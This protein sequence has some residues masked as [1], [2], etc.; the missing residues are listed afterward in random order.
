MR[1]NKAIDRNES[2]K[3][4]LKFRSR[5]YKET[6]KFE[7]RCISY[8][9][10]GIN[11]YIYLYSLDHL[12]GWKVACRCVVSRQQS[13]SAAGTRLANSL[14]WRGVAWRG[15]VW[16]DPFVPQIRSMYSAYIVQFHIYNTA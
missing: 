2:A 4:N 1:R 10:H 14:A 9:F 15:L 11:I 13:R 12:F 7:N 5:P 6:F 8:T 16:R 3:R